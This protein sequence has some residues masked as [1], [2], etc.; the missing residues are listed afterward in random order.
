MIRPRDLGGPGQADIQSLLYFTRQWLQDRAMAMDE[1]GPDWDPE[2]W[3]D[4]VTAVQWETRYD[5]GIDLMG[6]LDEAG[7]ETEDLHEQ[8]QQALLENF[9]PEL[10]ALLLRAE[11][12]WGVPIYGTMIYAVR[13]DGQGNDRMALGVLRPDGTRIEPI[14]MSPTPTI[15]DDDGEDDE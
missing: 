4:F 9:P 1:D 12:R 11:S 14:I 2:L 7:V 15:I 6:E 5:N 10:E 3:A 8:S 13:K